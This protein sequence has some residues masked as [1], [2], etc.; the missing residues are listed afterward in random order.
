LSTNETELGTF[1]DLEFLE[2]IHRLVDLLSRAYSWST[3]EHVHRHLRHGLV[4]RLL[5]LEQSTRMLATL[6]PDHSPAL[7]LAK[8]QEA[9][10]ALNTL[11][12]NIRGSLDN[13]AWALVHHLGL[14]VP[15]AEH[16]KKHRTFAQLFG[17]RFLRALSN[18]DPELA[19]R[20]EGMAAWGKEL[21]AFRDPAAHRIPLY[22]P[23]SVLDESAAAKVA[24]IDKELTAA[25]ESADWEEYHRC[26]E[27]R[28]NAGRFRQLLALSEQ[29]GLALVSLPVALNRDLTGLLDALELVVAF[30]FA[31]GARPLA[32]NV[33]PLP[34]RV[35]LLPPVSVPAVSNRDDG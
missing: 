25:A 5:M 16:L 1:K 26:M 32:T 34:K 20:L 31:E 15:T 30:V 3:E 12:L 18:R 11:F 4:R 21:A 22:I 27:E 33:G 7:S 17:T 28:W 13:A 35:R 19:Q 23:P 14:L 9:N 8:V 10:V 29:Q 6:P 24:Q 2:R